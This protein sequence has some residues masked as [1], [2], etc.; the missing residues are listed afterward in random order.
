MCTG[1]WSLTCATLGEHALPVHGKQIA[2]NL[3]KAPISSCRSYRTLQEL[4][5]P[6]RHIDHTPAL[7]E[8]SNYPE[9]LDYTK[10]RYFDRFFAVPPADIWNDHQEEA[11]GRPSRRRRTETADQRRSDAVSA[12]V[13]ATTQTAAAEAGQA[14]TMTIHILMV[15]SRKFSLQCSPTSSVDDLKQL[16]QGQYGVPVDHQRFIFAR[17]Q[18][19]NGTILRDLSVQ[20]DSTLHLVL[21]LRLAEYAQLN[22][23]TQQESSSISPDVTTYVRTFTGKTLTLHCPRT[24][25]AEHLRQLIFDSEGAPLDSWFLIYAGRKMQ[26][27]RTLQEHSLQNESRVDMVKAYHVVG[28]WESLRGAC[29]N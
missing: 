5:N 16:V 13:V 8:Q 3:K 29:L 21:K 22:D 2:A 18:L 20:H 14:N 6:Q 12:A 19:V 15:N 11:L 9:E 24:S 25:P 7:E 27:S 4:L 1:C 10:Q 17:R 28:T 26:D 23:A